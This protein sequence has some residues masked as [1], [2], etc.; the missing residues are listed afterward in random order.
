M[1]PSSTV[2]HSPTGAFEPVPSSSRTGSMSESESAA[3][4]A[5]SP[6]L[7]ETSA[8]S[9]SKLIPAVT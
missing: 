7:Q 3:T 1:R 8:N 4:S 5:L 9:V 2:L 6:Q